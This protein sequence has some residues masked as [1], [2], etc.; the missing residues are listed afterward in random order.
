MKTTVREY[1]M[2]KAA[3]LFILPFGFTFS[4]FG[5]NNAEI[6]KESEALIKIITSVDGETKIIEKT[7]KP[8]ETG[9]MEDIDEIGSEAKITAK[10]LSDTPSVFSYSYIFDI[11]KEMGK[12]NEELKHLIEKLELE[13][14]SIE[15]EKEM[16]AVGKELE[17]TMK[18][19][20]KT[21]VITDDEIS[22]GK[23]NNKKVKISETGDTIV[24]SMKKEIKTDEEI[25]A[26]DNGSKK[27][28]VIIIEE[29][30]ENDSELPEIRVVKKSVR[31]NENRTSTGLNEQ[32]EM[33]ALR[34]FPNPSSGKITV[35][36]SPQGK[37]KA[38]LK[39]T[40]P[41]GKLVYSEELESN[42]EISREIDLGSEAKG[43]YIVEIMQDKNKFVNRILLK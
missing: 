25:V 38:E 20:S 29:G 22:I 32:A 10:F 37:K 18:E 30:D 31:S 9:I 26:E 21:F 28:K 12:V 17:K 6:K 4:V 23:R 34:V 7:I 16:E 42:S 40:D 41:T 13:R 39:I 36:F 11:D 43:V 33:P 8:G 2:K 27:V 19:I 3:L 15:F 35:S 1:L 5:Q 24:I 14:N